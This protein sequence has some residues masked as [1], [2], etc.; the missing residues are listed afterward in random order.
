MR[1]RQLEPAA[2]G[3]KRLL[4]LVDDPR[5]LVDRRSVIR[6]ST[7]PA[8]PAMWRETTETTSRGVRFSLQFARRFGP[9]TFRFGILESTGGLGMDLNLLRD[10]FELRT[11]IFDFS[12]SQLP[13][14]RFMAAY[15]FLQRVYVLGGVD[16][17]LNPQRTDVF[18]GAQLRF[19]DED[20][21]TILLFAGSALT[22]AAR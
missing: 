9:A 11:D 6:T 22:G 16:D 14:L 3:A 12:S 5:G 19:R 7:N 2:D 15:A 10:R 21:R 20:L 17:V 8:D 4:Q 13:R 1:R 18:L